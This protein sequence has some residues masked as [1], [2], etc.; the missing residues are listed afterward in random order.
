M[1]SVLHAGKSL[2][3]RVPATHVK[4][5]PTMM[6]RGS[7]AD[8]RLTSASLPPLSSMPPPLL[9]KH[10]QVGAPPCA[11]TAKSCSGSI[12]PSA[13]GLLWLGTRACL[14]Q[15]QRLRSCRAKRRQ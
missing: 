1:W 7:V 15:L 8:H 10:T 4:G 9:L 12:A 5:C 6:G 13:A 11:C 3:L 2:A 14:P